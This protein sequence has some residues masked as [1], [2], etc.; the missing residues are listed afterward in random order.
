MKKYIQ[1]KINGQLE[2][3]DEMEIKTKEDRKELKRL[4]GEYR[5][6]FSQ[7]EIYSSQRPCKSW[8]NQ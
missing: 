1:Y 4:I 7:G 6:A 2:T 5:L 3:I 8:R